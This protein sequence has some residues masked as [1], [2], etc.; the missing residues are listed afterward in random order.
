MSSPPVRLPARRPAKASVGARSEHQAAI[1]TAFWSLAGRK[2][3]L[4]DSTTRL[5]V[6]KEARISRPL[7]RHC[8]C[9][10]EMGTFG[11]LEAPP[12]PLGSYGGGPA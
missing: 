8:P 11:F 4:A 2:H 3:G 12:R 6:T 5:T 9:A 7:T 10:R 1:F